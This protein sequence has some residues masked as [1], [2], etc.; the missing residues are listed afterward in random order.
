MKSD[1][2]LIS[3]SQEKTKHC[4]WEGALF[5]YCFYFRRLWGWAVLSIRIF[6]GSDRKNFTAGLEPVEMPPLPPAAASPH[7]KASHTILRMEYHIRA[8][9]RTPFAASRRSPQGETRG[10]GAIPCVPLRWQRNWIRRGA[11]RP[12]NPVTCF[13]WAKRATKWRRGVGGCK[14]KMKLHAELSA[15]RQSM[16]L[17]RRRHHTL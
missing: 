7:G 5:F 10:S 6:S 14:S 4:E 3:A 8:S 13:L 12:E 16:N 17:R 9:P 2:D 11:K 1:N 15:E